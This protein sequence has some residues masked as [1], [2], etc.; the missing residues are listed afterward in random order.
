[1][2]NAATTIGDA[3]EGEQDHV[4]H[5]EEVA[6][7]LLFLLRRELGLRQR[8]DAGRHQLHDLVTQR[9]LADPVLRGDE[10]RRDRVGPA[11]EQ[12]LGGRERERGVGD[13]AEAVGVAE[14]GDP[15]DRDLD[16]LG[17]QDRGAVPDGEVAVL[18]RGAV[19]D[20]L[21]GGGGRTT[22]GQPVGVQRRVVDPVGG[23]GGGTVATDALAV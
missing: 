20:D 5:A 16:R 10:H 1:M 12:L 3:G 21:V 11:G 14:R 4:E 19:D 22:L 15:D 13:R 9:L 23:G 7:D 6:L 2:L 8:L 18:R 17:R